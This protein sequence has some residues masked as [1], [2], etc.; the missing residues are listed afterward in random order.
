[1]HLSQSDANRFMNILHIATSDGGGAGLAACRL[2]QGLRDIGV[3]SRVLC[4]EQERDAVGVERYAIAPWKYK[5]MMAWR[6]RS[7]LG[8]ARRILRDPAP[9][10]EQYSFPFSACDVENHPLVQWADVVHLH[11][12]AHFVNYPAFFKR[13]RKPLVWT[14]HDMNPFLGGF[15]YAGDEAWHP[16]PI[17]QR[18]KRIKRDAL[19]HARGLTVVS[20]S[21]WLDACADGS[22]VFQGRPRRVIPN[23]IDT[24]EFKPRPRDA[25]RERFGIPPDKKTL[26]FVA[27]PGHGACL[28]KGTDLLEEGLPRFA[29]MDLHVCGI[30]SFKNK[31]IHGIPRVNNAAELAALYSAADF[32]ILP[33]R[34]DNLPNTMLEAMACGTPVVGT[35]V[36]GMLDFIRDGETGVLAREVSAGALCEAVRR[37]VEDCAFDREKIR[38][39]AEA[40]FS[41]EKQARAYCG[42]YREALGMR[43]E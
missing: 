26:L 28:R 17:D 10:Y 39:F 36:G 37:A 24:A 18:M 2:H 29:S 25:A 12:V 9:D 5:L 38:A 30:G 31:A 27:M 8:K 20:P 40:R 6:F 7:V 42:V 4:R 16:W 11:W 19:K 34:E 33:S 23:G 13:V 14:L 22:G 1:M 15:H 35:P 32:F 41:L 43:D 3:E 21:R